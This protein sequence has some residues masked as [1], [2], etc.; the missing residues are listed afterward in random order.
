MHCCFY[1]FP[2]YKLLSQ[3][4]ICQTETIVTVSLLTDHTI[5]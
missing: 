4:Y 5:C 3:V 2:I 1:V